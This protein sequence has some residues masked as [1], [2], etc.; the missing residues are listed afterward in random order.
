MVII[1]YNLRKSLRMTSEYDLVNDEKSFHLIPCLIKEL[2]T[3]SAME[4]N[5]TDFNSKKG[6]QPSANSDL[7]V[8]SLLSGCISK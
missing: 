5:I 8:I 3:P 4:L 2:P 1:I 6:K 7:K